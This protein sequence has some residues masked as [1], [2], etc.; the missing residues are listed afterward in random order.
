MDK[1]DNQLFGISER[2]K[3]KNMRSTDN[4]EKPSSPIK[5]LKITHEGGK[6]L[7]IT[8]DH[9]KKNIKYWLS[10]AITIESFYK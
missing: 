4:R 3:L 10:Q 5:W 7:C 1:I 9:Y 6:G 8:E 2:F